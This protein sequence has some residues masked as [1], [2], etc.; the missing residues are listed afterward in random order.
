[1]DQ[2]T[3]S[4]YFKAFGDPTRRRILRLLS[5]KEMTVNEIVKAVGLSQPTVS[6]H[7]AL[8]RGAGIVIDRRDGQKVYYSLDRKAVANCCTCFCDDLKIEGSV[9]RKG[10][11]K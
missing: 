7:L 4:R 2:K 9:P 10:K 1:M 3:F 6:R 8:L 5:C 11:K